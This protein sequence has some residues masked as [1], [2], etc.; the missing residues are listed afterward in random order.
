MKKLIFV[1]HGRA[2]E[3]TESISDFERSLTDKGKY[4]SKIMAGRLKEFENDPGMIITSPAFRALETALIFAREYDIDP[5]QIL[6]KSDL[7]DRMN[8]NT[9]AGIL[10]EI[11]EK[12]NTLMLFGHN[13]SFTEVPDRLSKGGCDFLPK[14]GIVCIT[15]KSKTW[16]EIIRE[17]GKQLYFL[18]PEKTL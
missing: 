8:L 13:P 5:G 17:K 4:V 18:K 9:L 3:L 2:E 7:Y 12:I 14:S 16:K 6:L 15:F 1:R 10:A 11:P